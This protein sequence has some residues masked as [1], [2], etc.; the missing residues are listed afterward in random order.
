MRDPS[1]QATSRVY[2]A[3]RQLGV[4]LQV[5][6]HQRLLLAFTSAGSWAGCYATLLLHY[7]VA[8]SLA[9]ADTLAQPFQPNLLSRLH[10]HL[11]GTKQRAQKAQPSSERQAALG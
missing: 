5:P 11:G 3:C 6:V 2:T 10:Q 4:L 8:V 1:L 7:G 9:R